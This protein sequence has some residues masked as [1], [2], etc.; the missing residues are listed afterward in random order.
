MLLPAPHVDP[1][2]FRSF[3]NHRAVFQYFLAYIPI[4]LY[5]CAISLCILMVKVN[6]CFE[7]Q[8]LVMGGGALVQYKFLTLS[9]VEPFPK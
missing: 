9:L 2:F 7:M 1:F 3:R 4:V 8:S 5:Y 6:S